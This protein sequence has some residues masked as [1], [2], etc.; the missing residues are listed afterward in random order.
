MK[1]L[2]VC[3]LCA[4]TLVVSGCTNSENNGDTST[5][6]RTITD[7]NGSVEIPVDPQRI[8][9]LSG[10]SDILSILGYDVVGTANSDGYD[11]TRFPSY[12]EDVLKGATILGY[13]M[14]DTMDVEAV[15]A[16]N[17]DLIVISKVQEKMYDALSQVAPTVMI[18]LKQVDWREDFLHVATVLDNVD[19]ANEW[20]AAYDEKAMEVASTV[21]ELVGDDKSYLA[22]L[23]SGGSFFIFDGAGLGTILYE[24][25]GLNRPVGM[26]G[27]ENV[28]L[29]VVSYEGL[30]AI[31]A[32]VIFAVATDEDEVALLESS[33]WNSL[34][35]V[36]EGNVVY[37]PASPYFNIGYSPIG[38]LVFLE[39]VAS[40]LTSLND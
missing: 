15:F 25:L 5:E 40:L 19:V 12:L 31:E 38:R 22:F 33:I 27:Q 16:L 4:F 20:L 11:Y 13:S 26:P 28:S 37:L 8:V 1:K 39:E 10:A 17:P 35:A 7:V 23:A 3:M 6:T 14:Q 21:N 29:P 2:L 9:D 24:D 32:D 30:A 34:P 36:K 18:D